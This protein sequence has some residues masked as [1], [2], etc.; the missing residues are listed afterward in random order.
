MARTWLASATP[1]TR[2]VGAEVLLESGAPD[3]RRDSLRWRS[4]IPGRARLG[5]ARPGA[6]LLAPL[7]EAAKLPDEAGGLAILALGRISGSVAVAELATLTRDPRRAWE[8][9]FALARAPGDD[10]EPRAR[11]G[12]QERRRGAALRAGL[13][14]ARA[15][16]RR[17]A[18]RPRR[19]IARA[20]RVAGSGRSRRGRFRARRSGQDRCARFPGFRAS[21]RGTR[22]R[23]RVPRRPRGR[24]PLR[25]ASRARPIARRARPSLSL[26]PSRPSRSRGSRPRS[27]PLGPSRT[28]RSPRSPCSLWE[29]VRSPPRAPDSVDLSRARS[30]VACARRAGARAEPARQRGFAAR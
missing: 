20:A 25:G 3:A 16:G 28:K 2:L 12:A 29:P 23:P 1:A 13:G 6:E 24:R 26:S 27:W 18:A 9:A 22:G 15:H 8:A 14:G 19:P 11:S 17:V 4:R 7:L 30:S 10:S 5:G 21:G